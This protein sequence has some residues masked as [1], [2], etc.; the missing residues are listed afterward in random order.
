MPETSTSDL[1]DTP[2]DSATVAEGGAALLLGGT[3]Q[4]LAAAR[5]RAACRCAHCV[6][7]RLDGLF[8]Q[9]VGA[10]AIVQVSAIGHYG[11]NIGFSDGHARGIYPWAY[12]SQLLKE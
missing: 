10:I 7:A 2:I 11:V 8:P 1:A 9:S 6:R 4:S 12:L 3:A 5:L